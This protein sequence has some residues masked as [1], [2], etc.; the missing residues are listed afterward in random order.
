MHT[1]SA[2]R[3]VEINWGNGVGGISLWVSINSMDRMISCIAAKYEKIYVPKQDEHINASKQS[4]ASCLDRP[5][6]VNKWRWMKSS[7]AGI[8]IHSVVSN[9]R[10]W[11]GRFTKIL[12]QDMNICRTIPSYPQKDVRF[13]RTWLKSTR[14]VLLCCGISHWSSF[15]CPFCINGRCV[16]FWST[17]Y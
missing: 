5:S 1:S 13:P 11:H 4:I 14:L 10:C 15:L 17:L 16:L 3:W 9:P 8:V 2:G 12:T 6:R 7:H